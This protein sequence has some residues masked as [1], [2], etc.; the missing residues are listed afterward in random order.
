MKKLINIIAAL[1]LF[2]VPPTMW[3]HSPS[4]TH[5]NMHMDGHNLIVQ[6]ELPWSV[7]N[8]VKKDYPEIGDNLSDELFWDFTVKYIRNNFEISRNGKAISINKI[9]QLQGSHSHSGT[10]VLH[11]PIQTTD[12]LEVRNTIMFNLTESQKNYHKIS[13]TDQSEV[14]FVTSPKR[15]VFALA[16]NEDSSWS[17]AFVVLIG[18]MATISGMGFWLF[19]KNTKR[20]ESYP[21]LSFLNRILQIPLKSPSA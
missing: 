16:A 14:R 13:L 6:L 18:L 9:K 1:I 5:T 19:Q 17:Y 12:Q 8:A 4:E 7:A 2:L 3:A 15:A 10:I 21:F 20:M 11:Y